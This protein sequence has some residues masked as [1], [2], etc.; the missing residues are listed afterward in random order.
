MQEDV[1]NRKADL[2]DLLIYVRLPQLPILY[3]LNNVA[4]HPLILV[5]FNDFFNNVFRFS[6]DLIY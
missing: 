4:K 6:F 5:V 2:A 3:F 1:I